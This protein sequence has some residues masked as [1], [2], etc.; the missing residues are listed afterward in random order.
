MFPAIREAFKELR[1]SFGSKP[2]SLDLKS[3]ASDWY[4]RNGFYRLHAL[5]E[6]YGP[7]WSGHTVTV[8]TAQNHSVVWACE[9]IISESIAFMPLSMMQQTRSGKYPANGVDVPLHPVY[10]AL[11]NAPN[12]EMTAMGFRE[13]LT[14]HCVMTGNC[15][16]QIYRRSGTGTAYELYPL[17]PEQVRP[18]RDKQRRLV[19]VVKD[20]NAA[21]R[22]YTVERG[23]PHDILHI[24]G[25]GNDGV[26]GYSVITMARQSIGTA[27]S[28]DKYAAKF[29]GT[30][31]RQPGFFEVANRWKSRED[32]DRFRDDMEKLYGS[33]DS[34]HKMVLLEP[35]VT[36]KPGGWS[37]Q[38]S[39]FLETRQFEIPE[40]CRWF[41]IS[42]H[43]V[44]DLSRATFSNIEH[45]AL[46]FVKMT[47][48]AWITRWEQELWRCVL[49]PAEKGEGYYFKHN[50]NG[51]LRGDFASRMA[52]YASALQN[53]HLVIN[54]VRD[55]E[56]LNPIDGGDD[57]HIQLNMQSL[58]GGTP[59]TA[60]QAALVKI[61]STGK[62]R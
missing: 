12:D 13:T 30:G 32:A 7:T 22:T 37:P 23:K 43:M 40:I 31:G 50:V 9:R 35:G 6:D 39:Q 55:L 57:A 38:D 16:A 51:L 28:A 5:H 41:L 14:A 25:L 34:H 27:Q 15:Y 33:P 17:L 29:F 48:T 2:I 58:P 46:Q 61:G 19:Y 11:H 59:T 18:D 44:G 36:F 45:L 8:D 42:P 56:D 24:R 10:T 20:G 47:L 3:A 62:R 60:Q 21:E 26:R 53:G 52:G 4:F 1:Q 49:T 54:E